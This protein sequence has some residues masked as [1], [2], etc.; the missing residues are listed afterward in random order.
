MTCFGPWNVG[1]T[2]CLCQFQAQ[3]F[4]PVVCFC[5][6]FWASAISLR[7]AFRG[8]CCLSS[9]GPRMNPSGKAQSSICREE[10]SPAGHQLEAEPTLSQMSSSQPTCLWEI[11]ALCCIPPGLCD[12]GWGTR[13]TAVFLCSPY[14]QL[15]HINIPSIKPLGSHPNL[16]VI[17]F[18]WWHRMKD[19]GTGP[20][21]TPTLYHICQRSSKY[22][23]QYQLSL[24]FV[25]PFATPYSTETLILEANNDIWFYSL[26]LFICFEVFNFLFGKKF[27]TYTQV[28]IL[29]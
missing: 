3:V 16:G 12:T 17:C 11:H 18:L 23:I 8:H 14:S 20:S 26:Y 2:N 9:P 29:W 27:Q 5:V 28:E 22:D 7:R 21:S 4:G 1:E 13:V 19:T 10:L 24:F 6:P 25:F 15:L